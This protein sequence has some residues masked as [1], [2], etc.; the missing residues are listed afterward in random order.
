MNTIIKILCRSPV[1]KGQCDSF[2]AVKVKKDVETKAPS[3]FNSLSPTLQS[4][5]FNVLSQVSP[6]NGPWEQVIQFLHHCEEAFD[7]SAAAAK[8]A[9]MPA[10]WIVYVSHIQT[11]E[12]VILLLV[13]AAEAIYRGA[14]F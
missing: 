13:K 14:I 7:E 9:N 4:A 1:F 6:N 5:L 11:D 10:N 8:Q 2:Y 12:R 3:T